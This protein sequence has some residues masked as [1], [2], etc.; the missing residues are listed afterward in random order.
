[1]RVVNHR[2]AA[3]W[4]GY[5][6]FRDVGV[7]CMRVN[8]ARIGRQMTSAT[9]APPR[10]NPEKPET[11]GQN[12]MP[13]QKN[14]IPEFR[15]NGGQSNGGQTGRRLRPRRK[16]EYRNSAKTVDNQTVDK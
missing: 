3:F 13:A 6:C 9:G 4:W 2:V 11:G 14:R 10:K 7:A 12:F 1:M 15:E 5:A 8:T 16:T